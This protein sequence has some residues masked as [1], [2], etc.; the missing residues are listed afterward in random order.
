MS[1]KYIFL[2]M[3]DVTLDTTNYLIKWHNKPWPFDDPKNCGNRNIAQILGM[4]YR[5]CW[6]DLPVEFWATIP[7]TP[8]GEAMVAEA[9]KYFPDQV[10][11]LTSPIPN[12]VCSHGKQL[13][14]N[15]NMPEY[16]NKMI[17]GHKKYVVVNEDGLL[18]DDSYTNEEKFDKAGKSESFFLFPSY[19]NKYSGIMGAMYKDPQLAINLIRNELVEEQLEEAE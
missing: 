15:K 14:V 17:I 13:W 19:Q 7:W 6:E 11:L 12:G 3:D 1:K 10:Y 9:E 16:K 2:D 8:W 5:E 18:I 4:S